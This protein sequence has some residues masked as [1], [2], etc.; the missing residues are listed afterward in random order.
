MTAIRHGHTLSDMVRLEQVGK[1]KGIRFP[2]SLEN[3]IDMAAIED[4]RDFSDEV[5][6]LVK[7]GLKRRRP[8][9]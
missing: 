4:S 8:T 3:Q 2:P 7:L 5:R 6:E 9:K 1:P